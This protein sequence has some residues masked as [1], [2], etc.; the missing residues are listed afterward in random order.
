MVETE[1]D[2]AAL[3][4]SR[5]A[6][7]DQARLRASTVFVRPIV[8]FG[9]LSSVGIELSAS[10]LIAPY[11]GSST[12]IWANLIG[13]TLAYLS[14]GYWLGGRM[15]DRSPKPVVLFSTTAV[16]AF[17]AGLIPLMSRPILSLSLD[18]FDD[19]DVGAFYGSLLGVLFLFAVPITLL[20]FVTPYAI[21]LLLSDVAAA[22]NTVGGVYALS[23]VGSIAGSF[24]PVILLI[25]LFGTANTFLI[26]SLTLLVGHRRSSPRRWRRS[27]S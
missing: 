18:A 1:L 15:A 27:S 11:F 26:L 22:G 7:P 23:T 19:V 3:V 4:G 9:G 6:T 21:R 25:P 5:T 14:L 2:P 13:L 16:A 20:G 12:F 8:F 24:L 10:R 17:V